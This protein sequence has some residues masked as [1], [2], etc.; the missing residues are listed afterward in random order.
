[1]KGSHDYWD[2]ADQFALTFLCDGATSNCV[3]K[4][5]TSS[6]EGESVVWNACCELGEVTAGQYAKVETWDDDMIGDDLGGHVT[7]LL[8]PGGFSGGTLTLTGLGQYTEAGSTVDITI[9]ANWN[10]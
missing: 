2:A 9:A 3:E 4:C 10:V 7:V 5:T 1:M 6:I 8:R